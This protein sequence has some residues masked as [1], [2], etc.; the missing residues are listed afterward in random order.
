MHGF[1]HFF[2]SHADIPLSDCQ[3]IY[4]SGLT[5]SGLYYINPDGKGQFLVY[6]DMSKLDG[7]NNGWTI[8]Q[9]RRDGSFDFN[10]NWVEYRN[11]FGNLK[12]NFWLGLES[13]KRLTD[14]A[15]HI[16]Y[17][18]VQ[19]HEADGTTDQSVRYAKYGTFGI[20][21]EA[22]YYKLSVGS[23]NISSTIV[24]SL[25]IKHHGKYFSTKDRDND[26]SPPNCANMYQAGWWYFGCADANLNGV[27]QNVG[28]CNSTGLP[29]GYG[30][31]WKTD[32][33]YYS[34]K[35]TVMAVRR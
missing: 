3:A 33:K 26:N 22:M 12:A 20:G 17:I 32:Q 9:R 27:W 10:R 34:Y 7:R 31:V 2:F 29:S 13:I 15:N 24:D 23:Y 35:T 28:Y 6:C 5:I 25:S 4:E 19:S 18:A 8:F 21:S 30:V 11:G 14:T 16:L 1:I